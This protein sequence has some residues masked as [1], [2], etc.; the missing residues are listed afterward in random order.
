MSWWT[1]ND[2]KGPGNGLLNDFFT[3]CLCPRGTV[4]SVYLLSC[5]VLGFSKFVKSRDVTL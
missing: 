1:W 3:L 2:G 4:C 5:S